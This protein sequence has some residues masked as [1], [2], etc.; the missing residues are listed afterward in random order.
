MHSPWAWSQ[1]RFD[2]SQ[3]NFKHTIDLKSL[4]CHTCCRPYFELSF[5][6]TSGWLDHLKGL[7]SQVP[8]H[9]SKGAKKIVIHHDADDDGAYEKFEINLKNGLGTTNSNLT[10]IAEDAVEK[11]KE[12]IL[13]GKSRY[14]QLVAFFKEA[15][16]ARDIAE[17]F[18][19]LANN[20]A[21]REAAEI[22]KN[23]VENATESAAK[24]K[25]ATS[26]LK[27][28]IAQTIMESTREKVEKAKDSTEKNANIAQTAL[29]KEAVEK[30]NEAL[31]KVDQTLEHLKS[32]ITKDDEEVD[33]L[34]EKVVDAEAK[35]KAAD[36]SSAKEAAKVNIVH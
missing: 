20:E 9:I 24:V 3:Q 28:A 32:N 31:A 7:E 17:M 36:M 1:V 35:A 21:A 26:V 11:T 30:A 18:A 27:K 23:A 25:E 4:T 22:A 19:P 8:Q 5:Q 34:L 2:L 33:A 15:L 16:K 29:A 6:K 13:T 10:K 14:D 12:S